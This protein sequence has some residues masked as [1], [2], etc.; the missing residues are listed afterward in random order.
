MEA[1][2]SAAPEEEKPK[3]IPHF[4]GIAEISATIKHLK[5]ARAVISTKSPFSSLIWLVQKAM[6]F[7]E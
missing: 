1:I 3:A 2:R 5:D 6:D 7:E 4:E